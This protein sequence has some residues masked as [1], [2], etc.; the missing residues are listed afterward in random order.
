MAGESSPLLNGIEDSCSPGFGTNKKNAWDQDITDTLT[1][2]A[3]ENPSIREAA[4]LL[5]DAVVLGKSTSS[6]AHTDY[7]I[8]MKSDQEHVSYNSSGIPRL[9]RKI[10][11]NSFVE[12]FLR[13]CTFALVLLSF[14][15]PPSW[16]REFES[17]DS[18]GCEAALSMV[19]VPAFYS[20]ES[21]AAIQPYYPN[22]K[23]TLLNPQQALQFEWFLVIVLLIHMVLCFGKD[24]FS[25]E[26]FFNLNL[27]R[28]EINPAT[29]RKIRIASIFRYIRVITLILLIK[30]M[31][32]YEDGV[33]ERF[34]AIP[35]RMLLFTTFFETVQNEIMIV[36]NIIP[37]LVSIGLVLAMIICLYG[38][39]GVA[40]FYNTSE[41]SEHFSNFVE[42]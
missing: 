3:A 8:S 25:L 35:L 1:L 16:C 14:I 41:G 18:K 7:L 6:F 32:S 33:S 12:G 37:A 24:G 11:V 2:L 30:G 10:L 9:C 31:I 40:A 34:F 20:D 26:T 15:E 13:I 21:E 4:F 29:K 17:G 36:L 5:R 27:A 42:G 39:V 23:T 22:T 28:L 38:A 19:G